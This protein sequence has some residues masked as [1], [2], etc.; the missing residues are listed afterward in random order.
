MT[1]GDEEHLPLLRRNA[2]ENAPKCNNVQSLTSPGCY[3]HVCQATKSGGDDDIASGMIGVQVR[4]DELAQALP[5]KC[6]PGD[7][8]TQYCCKLSSNE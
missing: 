5:S 7:R 3:E 2:R 8:M 4:T 6:W 1:D